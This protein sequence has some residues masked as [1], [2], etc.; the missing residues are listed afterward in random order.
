MSNKYHNAKNIKKELDN[1][2]LCQEHGT[3]ALSMTIAQHLLQADNQ[4]WNSKD[5]IPTPKTLIIGPSGCGKTESYRTLKKLA[6]EFRCPVAMFNI[7][8]Y[9]GS[10]SWRNTRPISDIFNDVFLQAADIYYTIYGDKANAEEQK[11]EITKIA[12]RAIIMIDEIDKISLGGEDNGLLMLR[13]Y[14]STLLKMVEG[15][16]YRVQ[17]WTHD[18]INNESEETIDISNNEVD[19]TH[20]MFVLLGA[21]TGIDRITRYRLQQEE[22]AKMKN[23]KNQPK[24]INYQDTHLGFIKDPQITTEPTSPKEPK[25]TDE[26]LIPSQEDIVRYG[27][28]RELVGR[29]SQVIVYKPLPEDALVNILLN[30]KT[31]AY[32]QYQRIFNLN[33]YELKCSRSALKEIA[34][35]AVKRGTGARGLST[36]FSEL[37]RDTLYEL[38][39]NTN[40]IRCLLRGKEIREGKPPLLHDRTKLWKKKHQ[41]VLNRYKMFNQRKTP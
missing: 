2:V 36:V 21:F 10:G 3:R 22:I 23:N 1:Y 38:S 16:A 27:F 5:A 9:S 13:E 37:L 12:N 31:S 25:Y 28:M 8:D 11:T 14:Q 17:D 32:K 39:G 26:Q 41:L 6:I 30:C 29:I 15:N 19:T 4:E 20:M 7:L 18:R 24:H 33:G 40:H 35:I 34:R